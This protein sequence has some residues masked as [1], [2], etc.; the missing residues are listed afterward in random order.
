MHIIIPSQT[1]FRRLKREALETSDRV[2]RDPEIK[3]EDV[4]PESKTSVYL[5]K[6]PYGNVFVGSYMR[7]CVGKKPD[8]VAVKVTLSPSD[9]PSTLISVIQRR[10][11]PRAKKP[12]SSPHVC[13]CASLSV[14]KCSGSCGAMCA[15]K[16]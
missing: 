11:A 1:R 6:H 7:F 2:T 12:S 10:L 14:E 8:K 3:T 15:C 5:W 4:T 13:R 9:D 16:K